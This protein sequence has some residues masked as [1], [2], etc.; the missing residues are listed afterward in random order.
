M[1]GRNFN[2]IQLD[3]S[4][5]H[6]LFKHTTFSGVVTE[7]MSQGCRKYALRSRFKTIPQVKFHGTS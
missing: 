4:N 2:T 1:A 6:S 5:I 7:F 3:V